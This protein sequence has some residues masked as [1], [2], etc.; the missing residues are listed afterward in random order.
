MREIEIWPQKSTTAAQILALFRYEMH[1]K[2][3][4]S[5]SNLMLIAL[6][7][8]NSNTSQNPILRFLETVILYISNLE[9][10]N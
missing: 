4:Q 2:I 5:L 6:N 8:K 3:A 7:C 1:S 10:P 9:P